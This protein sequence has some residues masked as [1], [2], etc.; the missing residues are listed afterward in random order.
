MISTTFFAHKDIH[1]Y[2]RVAR[3]RRER[4]II[5]YIIIKRKWKR[6]ERNKRDH[7]LVLV[8][9]KIQIENN[10][11]VKHTKVV[12]RNANNKEILRNY[13]LRHKNVVRLYREKVTR[14]D[15][16]QMKFK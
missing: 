1:N 7:F 14:N 5:D 11:K 16:Y 6:S 12:E 2:T 9:I 3:N 4:S 8:N 15:K 13:K 10:R